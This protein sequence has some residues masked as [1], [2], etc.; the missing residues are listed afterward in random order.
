MKNVLI[1]AYD[2]PPMGGGGVMR[3]AKFIK[4]LPM[5]NYNPIVL[6]VKKLDYSP[7]DKILYDEVRYSKIYRIRDGIWFE[8]F[9]QI[10]KEKNNIDKEQPL[11]NYKKKSIKI[12]LLKIAKRVKQAYVNNLVIPDLSINWVNNSI[13]KAI[14]I[15]KNENIDI[16]FVT[17]PPHGVQLLGIKLKKMFPNMPLVVDFRDGWTI[18]PLCKPSN[19]IKEKI[20]KK[21]EKTLIKLADKVICAT[22]PIEVEY[23]NIYKEFSNKFITITNG[24]DGENYNFN[25]DNYIK[26]NNFTIIYSGSIG[27]K[28]RPAKY[29]LEACRNIIVDK[30]IK[31]VLKIVFIGTFFE[32]KIYWIKQLGKNI[33]FISHMP[34]SDVIKFTENAELLM[35]TF[36]PEQGGKTVLTGKIFEYAASRRPI[37]GL[38]PDSA[39]KDFILNNNLGFCCEP[40]DIHAIENV[41]KKT[42]ELWKNNQLYINN[43]NVKFIEQYDR[44]KLAKKL[45]YLFDE[46]LR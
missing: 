15:I 3:V 36:L 2:F 21:Y 10:I 43:S 35:V 18:N 27:G 45:A 29:F 33:K 46:L 7:I 20:E 24:Y 11:E 13:S 14:D 1:I 25:E 16:I 6:T 5:Y 28:Q 22:N 8:K 32:D 44:R 38:V 39:A 34:Q 23:K 42:Y 30:D 41:I 26:D 9:K 31:K 19:K 4:Y 37:I 40:T 17:S 12:S